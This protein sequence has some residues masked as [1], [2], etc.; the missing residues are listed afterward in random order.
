MK[1]T[2]T[3]AILAA[4]MMAS[5]SSNGEEAPSINEQEEAPVKMELSVGPLASVSVA[6]GRAT[7]TGAVGGL[8]DANKWAGETFNLIAIGTNSKSLDPATGNPEKYVEINN[9]VVT[10]PDQT[11]DASNKNIQFNNGTHY[12]VGSN[13]YEFY[14]FHFGN[15]DYT[16]LGTGLEASITTDGL[17]AEVTINGTNDLMIAT[18]DK[19]SDIN[20]Q[21]TGNG[22]AGPEDAAKLYSAWSARKGVTPT[23]KFEH[24]LTRLV[25]KA[26]MAE[27]E[28]ANDIYIKSITLKNVASQANVVIIPSSTATSSDPRLTTNPA[29]LRTTDFVLMERTAPN[30][31]MDTLQSTLVTTSEEQVGES[32]LLI[33]DTRYELDIELYEESADHTSTVKQTLKLDSDAPFEANKQYTVNIKVY[34][35]QKIQVN[36]SLTAWGEGGNIDVDPDKTDF[37]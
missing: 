36:A 10:A 5:C 29:D 35:L 9:E 30:Q 8:A 7:G 32:V 22:T 25:F 23:L 33:P 16:D 17:T 1:K 34:G 6:E 2:W 3:M 14:A 20:D 31:P 15:A 26:K 28:T 18:T 19:A 27:N 12:Y 37:N 24:L 21:S 4:G 11:S 13:T